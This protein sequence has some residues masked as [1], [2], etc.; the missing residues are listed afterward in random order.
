MR[1]ERPPNNK[2]RTMLVIISSVIL[3]SSLNVTIDIKELV[4]TVMKSI[5]MCWK[6]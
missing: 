1:S 3:Y 6:M 5:I 2:V 4:V